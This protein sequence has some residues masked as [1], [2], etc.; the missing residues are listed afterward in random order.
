MV[1]CGAI[2]CGMNSTSERVGVYQPSLVTDAGTTQ[3]GHHCSMSFLVPPETP[4][5]KSLSLLSLGQRPPT[6]VVEYRNEC[7]CANYEV[8]SVYGTLSGICGELGFMH[9]HKLSHVRTYAYRFTPLCSVV[10]TVTLTCNR[11]VRMDAVCN[12]RQQGDTWRR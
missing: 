11:S 12:S 2:W 7:A 6:C 9:T 3:P 4:S 5:A 8:H 1:W 10:D